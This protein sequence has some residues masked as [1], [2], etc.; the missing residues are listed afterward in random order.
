MAMAR[1]PRQI[2]CVRARQIA[3]AAQSGH[4]KH[5]S[6]QL[7]DAEHHFAHC[8]DGSCRQEFIRWILH[9]VTEHPGR[10]G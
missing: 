1:R 8:N 10:Q 5:R 3:Q 4:G 9:V 2:S 6:D 7:Q